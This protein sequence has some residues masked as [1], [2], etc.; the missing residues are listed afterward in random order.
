MAMA[1]SFLRREAANF[2]SDMYLTVP[3]TRSFLAWI[4]L[5]K[6]HAYISIV[7]TH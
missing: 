3:R 5:E 1:S 2:L 6:V 4:K 7:H